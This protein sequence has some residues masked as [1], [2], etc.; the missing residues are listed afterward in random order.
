[1]VYGGGHIGL[2]GIAADAALARGG[3]VIGVIPEA[4]MVRELG[5]PGLTELRVVASMHERKAMMAGLSDGF[6]ALPGGF[7]TFEEFFEVVTWA[8]LGIHT[9]PCGLL[10]VDGYYDSLLMMLDRAVQD[11]F[12]RTDQRKL[13]LE[14][15]DPERILDRMSSYKAPL[16]RPKATMHQ[17]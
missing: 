15:S 1:M 14:D 11:E 16:L 12:I 10:N 7:G 4:L 5:H 6:I 13:V 8:Q 9:R 3:N 17:T 2:M